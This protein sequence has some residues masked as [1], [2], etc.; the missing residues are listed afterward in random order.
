VCWGPFPAAR[1]EKGTLRRSPVLPTS[2]EPARALTSHCTVSAPAVL[3]SRSEPSCPE[4]LDAPVS[5]SEVVSVPLP[6]DAGAEKK[7]LWQLPIFSSMFA[8]CI[9]FLFQREPC[10]PVRCLSHGLTDLRVLTQQFLA[11]PPD[12]EYELWL[13]AESESVT[14]PAPE[15]MAD[16]GSNLIEEKI[17]REAKQRLSADAPAQVIA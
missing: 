8:S 12:G 15:F 5:H 6:A 17:A 11:F 13:L 14:G 4:F 9:S 3:L 16:A 10:P 2:P 7:V 1:R